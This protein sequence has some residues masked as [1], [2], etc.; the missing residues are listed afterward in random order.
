SLKWRQLSPLLDADPADPESGLMK[1][2]L[3]D[4]AGISV[5]RRRQLMAHKKSFAYSAKAICSE[6]PI[7][8]MENPEIATPSSLTAFSNG[9]RAFNNSAD[10]DSNSSRPL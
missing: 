9:K 5:C 1:L 6:R 8:A 7:A 2:S 4:R 3:E 10:A